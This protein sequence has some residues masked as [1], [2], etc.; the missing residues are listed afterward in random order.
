VIRKLAMIVCWV[1]VSM[2]APVQPRPAP[3]NGNPAP[4]PAV[5]PPS[6]TLSSGRLPASRRKVAPALDRDSLQG[7]ASWFPAR[8]R[9]AAAGPALRVGAWRGSEM[10][11]CRTSRTAM[12]CVRVV[13]A[14]WC[15]CPHRLIDLSDDA[16]RTLA[17]L[18]QG[19]VRVTVSPF[20]A[21]PLPPTDT[22]E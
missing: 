19:L 4:T 2:A 21:A 5:Y 8:G 17:P 12:A 16:F 11:V 3:V 10:L 15:A 6:R 18:S 13:L 14:D 9:V 7:T 20:R 1:Y 22:E